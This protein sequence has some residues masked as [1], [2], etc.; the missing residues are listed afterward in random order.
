MTIKF[1]GAISYVTPTNTS[2]SAGQKVALKVKGTVNLTC[3]SWDA[4]SSFFGDWVT[5]WD[6]YNPDGALIG[7]DSRHHAILLTTT[8]DSATDEFTIYCGAA[9]KSGLYTVKLYGEEGQP[10]Y[11]GYKTAFVTVTVAPPPAPEPEPPVETEGEFSGLITSITPAEIKVGKPIDI[12]INFNA[13]TDSLWQQAN[14][15]WTRVIAKADSFGDSDTQFHNGRD[16][17]RTGQ[18]LHLG[19]M[20]EKKVAGMVTLQAHVGGILPTTPSEDGE[21]VTIGTKSFAIGY[22]AVAPTPTPTPTPT[23]PPPRLPLPQR[24]FRGCLQYRHGDGLPWPL[25]PSCCCCQAGRRRGNRVGKNWVGLVII[26]LVVWLLLRQRQP[27]QVNNE[28]TWS[29][30]DWLGNQRSI[31]VHRDVRSN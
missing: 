22:T 9:V 4:I 7:H 17:S 13:Y 1:T 19:T 29:W 23:P 10:Q 5:S 8:Q 14:G 20:P 30:T 25:A 11:L 12:Y 18:D 16:G 3:S 6:V 31:T 27:T 21:W 28:E 24:Q 15:W 2:F 26:G